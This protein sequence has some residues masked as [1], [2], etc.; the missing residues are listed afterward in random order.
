MA[1]PV[2]DKAEV[3]ID[4]PEKFYMGGFSRDS[5]FEAR[6]ENDGLF[7]RLLR[8]G[9]DKR[10]VEMHIHHKLLADILTE[11]A[12]SITREPPMDKDHRD[13]LLAALG[14]VEKALKR[15]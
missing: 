3:S 1:K 6:V 12:A 5:T 10:E 4:F 8:P 13:T 14:K 7:I 9:D 2:K 15:R 11:W